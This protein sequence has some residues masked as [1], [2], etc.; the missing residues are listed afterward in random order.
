MLVKLWCAAL[1]V[2]V[3]ALLGMPHV[4][5]PIAAAAR[6][7]RAIE[8]GFVKS[9]SA[10]VRHVQV[11]AVVAKRVKLIAHPLE[12]HRRH[13]QLLGV[14]HHHASR[15]AA[16]VRHP[17]PADCHQRD[18]ACHRL[19]NSAR[20]RCW[21]DLSSADGD[22]DDPCSVAAPGPLV[23]GP[24]SSSLPAGG[25][26][27]GATD[28]CFSLLLPVGGCPTFSPRAG[29]DAACQTE[30][31]PV[32]AMATFGDSKLMDKFL[33]L[34]SELFE[35]FL[36]RLLPAAAEPVREPVVPVNRISV[37][38]VSELIAAN[39]VILMGQ[40]A[41]LVETAHAGFVDCFV[42]I[43]DRLGL[44]DA[45][46]DSLLKAS[47]TPP[48]TTS[49]S[50]S[51]SS[52][53]A[54]L[55]PPLV[56]GAVAPCPLNPVDVIVGGPQF[57][58]GQPVVLVG[59]KSVMFNGRSGLVTEVP[60]SA[61][62]LGVLLWTESLPMAFLPSNVSEAMPHMISD[63]CIECRCFVNLNNSQPCG[64]PSEAV[65]PALFRS[66]GRQLFE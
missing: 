31:L 55:T 38:Q 56:G 45:E 16:A 22:L 14:H 34:Q 21:G 12:A 6:H 61:G 26:L 49:S 2:L 58:V 44:L 63:E 41:A 64:C 57:L 15:A 23:D 62:R 18:I 29:C 50:M 30:Q 46:V 9:R 42:K 37:A 25:V 35:K 8:L 65:R 27:C 11:A 40:T 28:P 52:P 66:F 33:S 24:C 17:V 3:V 1:A 47:R 19:A 32:D 60:N 5:S 54:A 10:D 53:S 59:L 36:L 20:H 48:P 13:E 43:R 51:A 4:R 7:A 39:S